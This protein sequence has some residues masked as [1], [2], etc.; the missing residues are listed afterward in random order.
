[1]SN[2]VSAQTT[3]YQP[4]GT[5]VDPST[6]ATA[7]WQAQLADASERSSTGVPPST[8]PQ[9][10]GLRPRSVELLEDAL[11]RKHPKLLKYSPEQARLLITRRY[12][13]APGPLRGYM[14]EAVF[15]DRNP[16]WHYVE[17]ANAPQHDVYRR[18]PGRQPPWN[19]QV[20][21]HDSLDPALYARDMV[22]D[23]R[24]DEFFIPDDHVESTKAYLQAQERRL[25]ARGDMVEAERVRRDYER[26]RPIKATSGE[27]R[28]ATREAALSVATEQRAVY[29]PLG[30]ALVL[31]LVPISVDW[32]NGN[33]TYDRAFYHAVRAANLVGVGV[34]TDK[35][36]GSIGQGA[37]RGT[38]RGN[39]IV[40]TA[41]AITETSWL[42]Y[43]YG[44]QSAFT[45]SDFYEKAACGVSTMVLSIPAYVEAT[46]LAFE[47]GPWALAIGMGASLVAGTVGCL[48]GQTATY[49]LIEV[50]A[51]EMHRREEWEKIGRAK[52]KLNHAIDESRT[53]Q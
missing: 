1:M 8:R 38:A 29:M 40:G 41:M 22:A 4:L 47:F 28:A 27:I 53:L 46:A 7:S 17:R 18:I 2:G 21:Y 19:G 14:A 52:D 16:E 44:W 49:Q 45:Q 13:K 12:Y 25:R 48:A 39:L 37:F 36:L 31:S 26:L 34:G 11:L 9:L 35:L 20:K 33:I 10:A 30:A 5:W 50:F 43:E 51:P 24:A 32:A 23:Y 3:A 42:L 6:A 15:V